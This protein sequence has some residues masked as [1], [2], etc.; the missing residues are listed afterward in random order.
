MQSKYSVITKLNVTTLLNHVIKNNSILPEELPFVPEKSTMLAPLMKWP[1]N[2]YYKTPENLIP[3]TY[4]ISVFE[5]KLWLSIIFTILVC[6]GILFFQLCLFK[7][8][9]FEDYL[10]TAFD[11]FTITTKSGKS[12]HFSTV[13]L[14][15]TVQILFFIISSIFSSFLIA[16]LSISLANE[17]LT[18]IDDFG[19]QN[20]YKLCISGKTNT[21]YTFGS[22]NNMLVLENKTTSTCERFKLHDKICQN[23]YLVYI[24]TENELYGA[25]L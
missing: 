7:K 23:P 8:A 25:R 2:F 9:P 20:E 6:F 14:K 16:E 15:H 21:T 10:E 12:R 24:S 17:P 11:I 5:W 4:F 19:N 18:K 13:I 3:T 1:H 22:F